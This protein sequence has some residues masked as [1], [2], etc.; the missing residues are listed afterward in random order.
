MLTFMA[1]LATE[2]KANAPGAV[3]ERQHGYLG[4]S[5]VGQMLCKLKNVN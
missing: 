1:A 5:K 3:S 4:T 2:I